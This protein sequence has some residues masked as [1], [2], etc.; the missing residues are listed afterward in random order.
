[1]K[2]SGLSLKL[3]LILTVS[4][5]TLVLIGFYAV[6]SVSFYLR[7]MDNIIAADMESSVRALDAP[8]LRGPLQSGMDWI[9]PDWAGM[10]ESVREHVS[11]PPDRDEVLQVTRIN[12]AQSRGPQQII[13]TMRLHTWRGHRLRGSQLVTRDRLADGG[14]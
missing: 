4:A 10:P 9:S 3:T 1:M 14:T 7:G 13:F 6:L 12:D 11:S 2:R 5:I 8:G